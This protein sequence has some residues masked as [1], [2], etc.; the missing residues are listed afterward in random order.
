MQIIKEIS[1]VAIFTFIFL[2]LSWLIYVLSGRDY[3][4]LFKWV[5]VTLIISSIISLIL[6][7]IRIIMLNKINYKDTTFITF[8]FCLFFD[9]IDFAII[10]LAN[11][12]EENLK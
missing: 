8:V 11:N 6:C 4:T 2:F 9:L 7:I 12:I 3:K 5:K 10:A 1:F